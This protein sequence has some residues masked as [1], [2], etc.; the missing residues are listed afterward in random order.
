MTK[1]FLV[2]QNTRVSGT[3]GS[4][5]RFD[6][7]F[8]WTWL[9]SVESWW[10]FGWR[11]LWRSD[12]SLHRWTDAVAVSLVLNAERR[13]PCKLVAWNAPQMFLSSLE[14]PFL[15]I[16]AC[17]SPV[18]YW[19][20]CSTPEASNYGFKPIWRVEWRINVYRRW[21][22]QQFKVELFDWKDSS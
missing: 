2:S 6:P 17:T 15:W 1:M 9:R 11:F 10:I 22:R 5:T 4:N 21:Q 18:S 19:F 16:V 3:G 12:C 13:E 8:S 14:S 7:P 20:C